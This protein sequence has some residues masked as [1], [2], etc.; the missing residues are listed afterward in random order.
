MNQTNNQPKPTKSEI[1]Q[2]A[3]LEGANLSCDLEIGERIQI[4][5]QFIRQIKD[6]KYEFST[7]ELTIFY[8]YI[9]SGKE[10]DIIIPTCSDY[11]QD[12]NIDS[13]NGKIIGTDIPL[14][15]VAVLD[16][17]ESFVGTLSNLNIPHSITVI[18]SSD[19][20]YGTQSLLQIPSQKD[21]VELSISET[22]S[23]IKDLLIDMFPN[24]ETNSSDFYSIFGSQTVHETEIKYTQ[25]LN[26]HLDNDKLKNF[27]DAKINSDKHKTMASYKR[28]K[29][30]GGIPD[31]MNYNCYYDNIYKDIIIRGITELLALGDMASSHFE[32]PVFCG[33]VKRI[34]LNERNNPI[35]K[36]A[37]YGKTEQKTIPIIANII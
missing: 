9:K 14:S 32:Q 26:N 3:L 6:S 2:T 13:Y 34:P 24:S 7:T 8:Q 21:Q 36:L 35:Y 22:K 16:N 17:L 37:E 29:K 12:E 27:I 5:K 31:D 19:P 30:I 18:H 25:S 10:I 4:A 33:P 28:A 11:L 15:L 1:I 20:K 23:K